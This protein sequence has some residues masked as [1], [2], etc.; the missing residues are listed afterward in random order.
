MAQPLNH[1]E[2]ALGAGI[3][4]PKALP[5]RV[6]PRKFI[7]EYPKFFEE[8]F[9]SF[10]DEIGRWGPS[11]IKTAN[12]NEAEEF[13]SK[14]KNEA[15][16]KDYVVTWPTVDSPCKIAIQILIKNAPHGSVFINEETNMEN[17]LEQF[18][19]RLNNAL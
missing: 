5:K 3:V 18:T 19:F 12:K 9:Q 11:V 13:Q 8:G 1:S 14:V 15:T 7:P 2:P 10:K 16:K 4:V 17:L 6:F